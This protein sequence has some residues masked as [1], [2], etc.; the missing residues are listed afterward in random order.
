[1][2]N[3]RR[4]EKKTLTLLYTAITNRRVSLCVL[5]AAIDF[6]TFELS[7]FANRKI[8]TSHKMTNVLS[9]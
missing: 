2:R 6:R 1:M 5:A 4:M 3:L 8:I 9:F 7:V